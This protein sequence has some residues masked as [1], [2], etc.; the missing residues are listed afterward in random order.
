[1]KAENL[2]QEALRLCGLLG[3]I[4]GRYAVL[5]ALLKT[6]PDHVRSSAP[7]ILGPQA[8]QRIRG[9]LA[10]AGDE[11]QALAHLMDGRS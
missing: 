7:A 8:A 6:L 2:V 10:E 11:F 9:A 4:E 1:M 3:E 5:E